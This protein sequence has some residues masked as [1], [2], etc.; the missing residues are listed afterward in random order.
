MCTTYLGFLLLIWFPGQAYAQ[1]AAQPCS[2][3]RLDGGYF[4]PDKNSYS[5]KTSLSYACD[6]GHKPVGEGWW[7][8]STCQNGVWSPTPQCIDEKDCI[9]PNIPNGR[10]TTPQKEWF[11]D[12]FL[13]RVTCDRGYELKNQAATATCNNGTWSS[14]PICEKSI[15]SCG[16]PPKVPHAVIIN[17]EYQTLFAVDSEVQYKC[18]DGYTTE[19][20]N[21]IKSFC[22]SGNWTEGPICRF[23]TTSDTQP[24]EI[25]IDHCAARPNVPNGDVIE[26]ERMFVKYQCKDFYKLHGSEKVVCYSNGTWSTPP[27]CKGS[28]TTSD[29]QPLEISIDHCAA[30]PNV[31]NGDIIQKERMFVK[32]QCKDFYKLHGSE[33]VVCYSN[34]TWSAPPICKDAFCVL[35]RVQNRLEGIGYEYIKE[36]EQKYILCHNRYN[37]AYVKCKNGK[38]TITLRC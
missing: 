30:P 5:H 24:L 28:S 34:G 14:L 37:Y 26:K 11:K 35:D 36:G 31:P 3:P 6:D 27:I 1:S 19:G 18:E 25:S 4:V 2:A 10:Y 9:S 16:E 12:T 33:K 13:I 20:G 8:T 7:A 38:P 22:L 15:H 32:Y 17:Q 21:I 29:T 23:S